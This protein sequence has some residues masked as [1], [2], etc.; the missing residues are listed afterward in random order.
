MS[1]KSLSLGSCGAAANGITLSNSTNASPIVVT[2]GAGHGLK[3][4][5]RIAISGITGN[6][7]ANGEWSLAAVGATTATLVGSAGNGAHGGS[8]VVANIC[9]VSPHMQRNAATVM[10][11]GN[12][13]VGTAVVEGSDDNVSWADV[14]KGVA[15]AANP[16]V[17]AFEVDLRRYMRL[18]CS[19]YTSGSVNAALIA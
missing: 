1:T 18:R 17:T 14:K 16:G 19:A 3:S 11:G 7:N 13:F 10:L 12:A 2:L 4:G 9:D 6:T 15:L 8:P 5:D